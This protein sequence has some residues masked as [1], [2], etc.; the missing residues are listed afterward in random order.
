MARLIPLAHPI[1][2]GFEHPR[3]RV[4]LITIHDLVRD[5]DAVMG[6]ADR[7]RE[8]FPLWGWPSPDM[9]L[10]QDLVDLGWHQKEA[11]MRR[12]FNYA[13]VSLDEKRLL[14]CVYVDPPEKRGAEAEVAFWVRADE[15]GTGLEEELE[16]A[17]RAWVA[18]SWPF[19]TVRWPGRDI[20][21]DEW[22][23]LSDA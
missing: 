7:L 10:E 5:F 6:S 15:E 18:E 17:V 22:A 19:T 20:S 4:R 16:R 1:P 9:T 12:S 8:R 13:V 14:G 2:P 3:F 23:R 21:W 11:E